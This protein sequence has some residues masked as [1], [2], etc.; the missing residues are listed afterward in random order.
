MTTSSS[1]NTAVVPNNNVILSD[2]KYVQFV[3]AG[4][5]DSSRWPSHLWPIV[6]TPVPS[7]PPV[8]LGTTT[9]QHGCVVGAA[10]GA[11]GI[12]GGVQKRRNAPPPAVLNVSKY[13][14][15]FGDVRAQIQNA[16]DQLQQLR[17]SSSGGEGPAASS[18]TKEETDDASEPHPTV[19][20]FLVCAGE[21]DISSGASMEQVISS[22][23]Q[24]VYQIYG[25]TKDDD[26]ATASKQPNTLDAAATTATY[27]HLVLLIGPKLEPWLSGDTAS[28]KR[29]VTL[30]RTLRRSCRRLQQE[31]GNGT[32]TTSTNG[33]Q[34]NDNNGSSTTIGRTIAYLDCMTTFCCDPQ[35]PPMAAKRGGIPDKRY[36]EEDGLHLSLRGYGIWKGL[37]ESTVETMLLRSTTIDR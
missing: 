30:N 28:R 11:A 2:T 3:L 9:A 36:F 6:G 4:D 12:G 22:F 13:G 37:V 5:S 7:S 34:R 20:V 14:A 1:T 35:Q 8:V 24:T 10:T 33:E 21:N 29:Y 31:L 32:T 16:Q 23:E 18:Q 19:V 15:L 25:R 17:R 26:S 27:H